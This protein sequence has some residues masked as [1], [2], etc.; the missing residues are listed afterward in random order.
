MHVA[1]LAEIAADLTHATG[2]DST[3]V[4]RM[5]DRLEEDLLERR[6]DPED[7]DRCST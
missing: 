6:P 5:I 2:V 7:G 3:A 4:T 1:G